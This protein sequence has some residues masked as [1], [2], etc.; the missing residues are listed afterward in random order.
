MCL[1]V[2][3][4]LHTITSS[5]F[6]WAHPLLDISSNTSPPSLRKTKPR[7]TSTGFVPP[8]CTSSLSSPAPIAASHP[9]P[10]ASSRG[11]GIWVLLVL[12]L[13]RLLP[14]STSET[15]VTRSG[16]GGR[17]RAAK[18]ASAGGGA[19]GDDAWARAGALGAAARCAGEPCAQSP[20]RRRQP[21]PP[22]RQ[23]LPPFRH[24]PPQPSQMEVAAMSPSPKQ[25]LVRPPSPSRSAARPSSLAALIGHAAGWRGPS[26]LVR[27]DGVA[28][29]ARVLRTGR[30]AS[31]GDEEGGVRRWR[32]REETAGQS[33]AQL[34]KPDLGF[35]SLARLSLYGWS[36]LAMPQAL[37][38]QP[39]TYFLA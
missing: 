5:L 3:F 6:R 29:A 2:W 36:K 4:S 7:N 32:E 37:F 18:V 15:P 33:L 20:P 38:N 34:G 28:A 19:R 31:G 39:N 25:S 35:Q 22:A 26:M 14:Q 9:P 17:R 21:P 16:H 11:C 12:G 1:A 30:T 24:R 23:P 10:R 8:S 27:D 13:C